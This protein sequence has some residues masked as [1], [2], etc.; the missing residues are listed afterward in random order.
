VLS[1][2]VGEYLTLYKVSKKEQI[3]DSLVFGT[4]V[5]Y[6][7]NQKMKIGKIEKIFDSFEQY[8]EDFI[9]LGQ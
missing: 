2:D 6:D 3:E 4:N 7:D 5:S 9:E 8:F 1:Y